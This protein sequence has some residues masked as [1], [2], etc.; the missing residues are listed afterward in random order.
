MQDG[1]TL[2]N[3]LQIFFMKNKSIFKSVYGII[4]LSA[5]LLLTA[6]IAL[7]FGSVD[8]DD[9]TFFKSLFLL[10]GFET[11]SIILYNLR[12]PR[13]L[14]AIIA[15][16][17]L[18]ISGLLLQNV[19]DNSLAGPN[20]IGVNAGAGFAVILTMCVMPTSV[21]L[22]PFSAFLGAFLTTLIIVFVALAVD[23]NKSTVILV[24]V[25]I[26]AIL[27]ALISLISLLN[28]DLL[29]QYNYFSVGGL[30]GVQFINLIIPTILVIVSFV[31]TLLLSSR[32]DVICLGDNVAYSLG[33][34]ARLFRILCLAISSA[35]A[36]AVVSFAGL[37]GFVGLVVPHIAKRLTGPLT[38]YSV[39]ASALIGSIVVLV[40]D[41]IGRII[42]APSEL[43]VGII[44]ALTGAPFFFSLLIRR[45]YA[46]S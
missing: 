2:M 30:S 34:N 39:S 46:D 13:I 7:R 6:I 17:G 37:L 26:T 28:P 21:V 22:V 24:G 14:G 15:G 40:A 9:I 44:M 3:I 32:I 31:I 36:A 10:D 33:L 11:Y 1:A 5:I 35:C 18:S 16:M 12:M 38:F 23:S 43:P 29:A 8:I 20:I 27:N 4:M 42:F 25:A 19:T 45:K 41:L